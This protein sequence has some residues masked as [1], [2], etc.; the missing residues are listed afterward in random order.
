[1]D[2]WSVLT[3]AEAVWIALGLDWSV[4]RERDD[5]GGGGG[6]P[7]VFIKEDDDDDDRFVMCK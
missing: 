3:G 6:G 5:G 2:G 1:M 7:S 4:L